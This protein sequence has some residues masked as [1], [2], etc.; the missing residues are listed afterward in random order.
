MRIL[1]AS[2]HGFW[3]IYTL[4]DP[5]R[6]HN[7]CSKQQAIKVVYFQDYYCNEGRLVVKG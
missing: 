1:E 5:G 2:I 7:R 6:I 3:R 4:Q